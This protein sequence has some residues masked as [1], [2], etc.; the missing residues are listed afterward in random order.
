MNEPIQKLVAGDHPI[1]ASVGPEKTVERFK[2]AI[3]R[4]HVHI[5]FTGTRG[6]TNLG[7]TLDKTLSDVTKADFERKVGQ[8][9]LCGE[10]TLDYE[11]VRCVAEIDLST[12]EGTGRLELLS[13]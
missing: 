1:E 2:S 11:R 9:K 5:R 12:L 3:D 7:F 10:L 4:E 8:V 13:Q 6:G